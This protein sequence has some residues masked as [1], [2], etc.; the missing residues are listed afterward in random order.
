MKHVPEVVLTAQ[1]FHCTR[2]PLR[3][4]ELK[5]VID[6]IQDRAGSLQ[7]QRYIPNRSQRFWHRQDYVK[8]NG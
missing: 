1:P 4:I 6:T 7:K 2:S 3:R 5:F 8:S